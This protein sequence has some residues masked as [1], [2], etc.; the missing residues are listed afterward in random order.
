M[1][2][3]K[4]RF[5]I[6][7]GLSG[8][9]KSQAVRYFE[10]IGFFCVD[11]LPP[12]LIPEFSELIFKSKQK[13]TEIALVIDIRG[14]GFFN[15]LFNSLSTLSQSGIEY[16]ILFLEASEEVLLKRFIETRRRHPLSSSN[17]SLEEAIGLERRRL[18][19]IRERADLIIDTSS[20][21]PRQ[22]RDALK[23]H[24]V[25]LSKEKMTLTIL[26]FGYKYGIPKD[27]DLVFDVRF[28]P[29]P[30]YIDD[31]R[32]LNGEDKKVVDYVMDNELTQRFMD[33]FLNLI[34]FLIP[35]YIE[36]GKSY[37]TIAIGCTGGTHR[38]VTIVNSLAR[39]IKERAQK[40]NLMVKHRDI[41]RV[42]YK[43]INRS[44]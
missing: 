6:I 26:S 14:G 18:T 27:A 25:D 19:E 10:D 37:L 31:L 3:R 24:F 38:S 1:R 28:L 43:I 35:Q 5:V 22:L 13:G 33:R 44:Y 9:G 32:S 2:K 8:A 4:V 39:F 11:N 29:N 20:L 40:V 34:E 36:E 7:T 41:N 42:E 23:E 16:R 12:I 21:T 30:H 17:I 15:E